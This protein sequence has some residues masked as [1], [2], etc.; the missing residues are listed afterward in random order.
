ARLMLLELGPEQAK[1]LIDG[2]RQKLG[3]RPEVKAL[4]A[5][6]WAVDPARP[7]A[8]PADAVIAATDRDKLPSP[9][10]A[11]PHVIEAVQAMN[12]KEHKRAS[13]EIASAISFST[14]PAL[15]SR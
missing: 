6:A 8:L 3:D 4:R 10:R 2:L 14:T 1:P 12:A 13:T 7:E 5:L 11:M 15:A 9:L